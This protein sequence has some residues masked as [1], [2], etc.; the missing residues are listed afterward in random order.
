MSG[1]I[2]VAIFLSRAAAPESIGNS[3]QCGGHGNAESWRAAWRE[4]TAGEVCGLGGTRSGGMGLCWLG[5][6]VRIKRLK[7]NCSREPNT[8]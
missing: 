5:R 7:S 8:V 1:P 3:D 2:V 6:L 4:R